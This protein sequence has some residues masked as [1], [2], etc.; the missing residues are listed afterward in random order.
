MSSGYRFISEEDLRAIAE[1]LDIIVA[2]FPIRKIE[3]LAA[4]H[5]H[6]VRALGNTVD[7]ENRGLFLDRL[8]NIAQDVRGIYQQLDAINGR[9]ML[10]QQILPPPKKLVTA[11]FS[12]AED[13]VVAAMQGKSSVPGEEAVVIEF[14]DFGGGEIR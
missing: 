3:N 2:E 11:D 6:A 8:T 10:A 7:A 12:L 4:R 5:A 1:Y 13:R 14:D 9:T